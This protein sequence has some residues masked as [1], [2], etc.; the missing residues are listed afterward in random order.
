MKK[1]LIIGSGFLQ[2]FVIQKSVSMG[3]E[4][5]TVD[6]DPNAIGFLHAHKHAVIDIVDEKACYEYAKKENIDGVLTAATDYGVLTAAYIAEHM[7]LPGLKYETAKLIKNKYEV[8][9]RLLENSVDDSG[10]IYEIETRSDIPVLGKQLCYPVMVKPCDGSGSRGAGRADDAEQFSYIYQTAMRNSR[11]RRVIVEPFVTGQ[12]YGAESFVENGNVHVFAVMK[13]WMTAPPYYA[14]LGHAIPSGLSVDLEYKVK[15]CVK[16]TISALGI[17]FGAVNMDLLITPG[18]KVHI[19]DIGARMGGNLIGSHIIPLGTG[20]DYM[21]NLIRLAAGDPVSM[22]PVNEKKQ[23][24]TKLL[25]LVPGKVKSLPDI[26]QIEKKYNV[27]IFHHLH[28]GDRINEYHTNLDGCGY[29]VATAREVNAAAECAEKARE[30]FDQGVM[31]DDA[32]R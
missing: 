10:R 14:E 2:D 11:T 13:K 8:R 30:E 5:L 31:R 26:P 4:T 16:K 29:V 27:E 3:Y 21:A 25:A 15:E 1:M 6:S 12:E 9:K 20:M 24:A 32:G 28:I 23:V 17:D 18:G 7:R 22:E 19:V